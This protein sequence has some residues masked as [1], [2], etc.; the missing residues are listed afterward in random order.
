MLTLLLIRLL[1]LMLLAG[2]LHPPN[3]RRYVTIEAAADQLGVATKTI[4]RRIASGE[5]T[6]YKLGKR[7]I[8]VRADDIENLLRE[9]PTAGGSDG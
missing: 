5:L 7:T 4:R 9:I 2:S 1:R 3:T 8:R 6:G